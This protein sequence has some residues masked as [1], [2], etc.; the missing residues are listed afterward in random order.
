MHLDAT[1]SPENA[2]LYT[3]EGGYRRFLDR[4]A[5]ARAE[6]DAVTASNG[7]A[8]DAG[9]N[10]VWHDNFAYEENQRQ[11][12]Q[13]ARRVRDME[14]AA[15]RLVIAPAP[16]R[17]DRVALGT[18]VTFDD[19]DDRSETIIVGG[20]EDSEPALRRVAYTAPLAKA[21]LGAEV[22]DTRSISLGGRARELTVVSISIA[23]AE[24][25]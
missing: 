3:T 22:G 9:D 19:A 25:L 14:D 15:R 7:D 1:S 21:L 23:A 13:L 17:A 4:I 6:Y 24:S 5:K 18:V 20:Y 10:S 11:M 12:H 16:T 8:A 2:P